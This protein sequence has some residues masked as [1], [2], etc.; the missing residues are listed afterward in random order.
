MDQFDQLIEQFQNWALSGFVLQL[1]QFVLLAGVVLILAW[2]ARKAVNRTISDNA[3]R[4]KAR[5]AIRFAGYI[6]V[7]ILAVASFAGQMQYV[8]VALGLITAGIAF[9][10]QSVIQSMAGWVAILS[11]SIYKPGD[12]IE[13]NGVKGDVIDIG[14][15]KTTLMEIGEWV[16]SDNYS[17]RIVKLSNAF[18]FKGPVC[19]YST[20]FP[21][22]WDEITLPVKYGSD[23]RLANELILGAARHELA[24]YAEYAKN[25]WKRML[26]IY[27]IEDAHVEPTLTMQ[28]TDNWIA[29]NLRYVVDYKKRRSTKHQLYS[30]IQ[31]A[32]V[33][34]GGKVELASATFE[35]VDLPEMNIRL[36]GRGD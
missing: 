27:L 23:I 4:Y 16:Q 29:F 7:I 31:Q 33:K 36:T 8:T 11:G 14:I 22:V 15:T 3:L 5:K 28:L 10:L 12:R 18:V 9:A 13:I 2:L 32:I 20:D 26:R 1:V 25:H 19:N 21:F 35:L 24:A 34:S 17:G 30:E 6:L